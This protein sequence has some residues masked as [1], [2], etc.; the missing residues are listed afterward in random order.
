MVGKRM[1]RLLAVLA[2]FFVGVT[3][4]LIYPTVVHSLL[5]GSHIRVS[6][7]LPPTPQYFLRPEELRVCLEAN[8]LQGISNGLPRTIEHGS[9][10]I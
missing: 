9:I 6:C 8:A 10:H 3:P 4:A 1:T 5:Q 7:I 2:M